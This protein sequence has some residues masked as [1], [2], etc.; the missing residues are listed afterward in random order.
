MLQ[1]LAHCVP[2]PLLVRSFFLDN[3][4]AFSGPEAAHVRTECL[5]LDLSKATS[6]CTVMTPLSGGHIW[7]G[8]Q[9]LHVKMC[10]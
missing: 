3:R 6:T 9:T 2:T 8:I 1:R 7:V 4:D 5:E 10:L